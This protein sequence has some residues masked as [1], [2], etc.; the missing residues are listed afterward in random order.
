MNII[1]SVTLYPHQVDLSIKNDKK[2]KYISKTK[3]AE[4]RFLHIYRNLCYNITVI[5]D[6]LQKDMKNYKENEFIAY[7][8]FIQQKRHESNLTEEGLAERIGMSDREIRN[9]E[10]GYVLPKL[11][12]VIRLGTALNMNLGD[13]NVL[14]ATVI[15]V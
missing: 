3:E 2:S 7:G 4:I 15:S 8:T 10:K 14:K 11:D 13:L 12:T 9:I 5:C 6:I 1:S